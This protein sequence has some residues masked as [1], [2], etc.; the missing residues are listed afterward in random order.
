MLSQQ[1]PRHLFVNSVTG[2]KTLNLRLL[3]GIAQSF[4]TSTPQ[5]QHCQK[6]FSDRAQHKQQLSTTPNDYKKQRGCHLKMGLHFN[7]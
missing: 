5:T 4:L 6:Q 2:C 7:G 1:T 3:D